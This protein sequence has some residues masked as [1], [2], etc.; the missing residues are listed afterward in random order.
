M[1]VQYQTRSYS[2]QYSTHVKSTLYVITTQEIYIGPYSLARVEVTPKEKTL[3]PE[4][5]NL[6]NMN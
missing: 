4:G 5:L 1:G 3:S 2:T 6:N